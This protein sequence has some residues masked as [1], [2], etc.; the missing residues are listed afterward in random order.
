YFANIPF[1]LATNSGAAS[2]SAM[3]PSSALVTSGP[4]PSAC[5]P[6]GKP[7]LSAPSKAAVPAL[8]LRKLRRLTP[9]CVPFCELIVIDLCPFGVR[10]AVRLS[11]VSLTVER[12]QKKPQPLGHAVSVFP[13]EQRRCCRPVIGPFAADKPAASQHHLTSRVPSS[14]D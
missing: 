13:Q 4:V 8:A 11:V 3:K 14:S 7:A 6:L 9:R 2:V 1:S 10:V 12:K 5:A